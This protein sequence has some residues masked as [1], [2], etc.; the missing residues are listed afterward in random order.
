MVTDES[1]S[2]D[3]PLRKEENGQDSIIELSPDLTPFGR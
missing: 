3:S 1:L 2:P